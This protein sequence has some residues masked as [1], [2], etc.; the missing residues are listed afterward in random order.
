MP[1]IKLL[2]FDLDDT[3]WP[4]T[5]TLLRAE[6][7]FYKHLSQTA[8]QLCAEFSPEALRDQRRLFLKR[9]PELRDNI[10]QWRL[11]S[12]EAALRH[13]GYGELSQTLALDAFSVFMRARQDVSLFDHCEATIAALS[14]NYT[15]ISLTNGNADLNQIPIGRYFHRCYRA[16]DLGAAKPAPALFLRALQDVGCQANESIHI[17]DHIDDDISGAKAVG[18]FAIQA[19][20]TASSPPPHP[21]AD[22]HFD[23]WRQL[24]ALLQQFAKP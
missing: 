5:P 20:L 18:M 7:I 10:S 3:L 22:R 6:S 1:R 4:S 9:H 2:C 15:L 8:P 11:Q 13:T 23:D 17:G 24:P 21:S 14:Q 16:E 19:R 12:L